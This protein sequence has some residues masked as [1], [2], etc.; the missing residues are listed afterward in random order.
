MPLID[1]A[2][3]RAARERASLSQK[4]LSTKLKVSTGAAGE[5][6]RGNKLP[7]L[8]HFVRLC[9]LLEVSPNY[10]LGIDTES[11][12][13]KKPEALH[14]RRLADNADAVLAD[15]ELPRGLRALADSRSHLR[16]LRITPAEWTALASL[17]L[18]GGLTRD[19]Y[20]ALLV[21]LR[22]TAARTARA[23]VVKPKPRVIGDP[24]EQRTGD[25][26]EQ[27]TVHEPNHPDYQPD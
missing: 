8:S 15:D 3:L 7:S 19:G 2:R 26:G 16:A 4:A 23:P 24:P 11:P 1:L 5:W 9:E 12:P 6:E 21:L 25:T 14:T 13:A 22:A 10:L 27:P 18:P 17:S 20:V